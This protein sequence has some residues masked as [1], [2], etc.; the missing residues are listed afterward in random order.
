MRTGR[1]LP[2]G[3][4]LARID[5]IS[6]DYGLIRILTDKMPCGVGFVNMFPESS[7]SVSALLP[8]AL[9]PRQGRGITLKTVDKTYSMRHFVT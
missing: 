1:A 3:V 7:T 4:H 2:G 8:T 9:L 6:Y 5:L